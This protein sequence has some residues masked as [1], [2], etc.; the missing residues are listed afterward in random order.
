MFMGPCLLLYLGEHLPTAGQEDVDAHPD[1]A[2]YES[3]NEQG[4]GV[5]VCAVP[6]N[7]G[8]VGF[9]VWFYVAGIFPFR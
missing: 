4:V 2:G 6:W 5:G 3:T 9:C 1:I 7:D 8:V